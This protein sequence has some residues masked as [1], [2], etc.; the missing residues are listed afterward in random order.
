[1]A[2]DVAVAPDLTQPPTADSAGWYWTS[3]S[4]T[5]HDLN[6][7]ADQND[8]LAIT[9]MINGGKVNQMPAQEGRL[10]PSQI[11]VLTA[12]VWGL[13][14]KPVAAAATPETAPAKN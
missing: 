13:S 11:H 5:R 4:P 1:M 7:L 14:N 2:V 9:A 3:G 6:L 8:F 10:T 12:Y